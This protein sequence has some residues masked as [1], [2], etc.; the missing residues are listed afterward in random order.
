[1]WGHAQHFSLILLVFGCSSVEVSMHLGYGCAW[2]TCAHLLK[3]AVQRCLSGTRQPLA[4][5]VGLPRRIVCMD[6]C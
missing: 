5:I 1:M 3:N 4:A 6:K 2:E